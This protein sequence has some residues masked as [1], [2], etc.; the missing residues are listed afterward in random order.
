MNKNLFQ[1]EQIKSFMLE[2]KKEMSG[3]VINGLVALIVKAN[4]VFKPDTSSDMTEGNGARLS[5]RSL[6]PK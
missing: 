5:E 1:D 3:S 2:S 6:T 4:S